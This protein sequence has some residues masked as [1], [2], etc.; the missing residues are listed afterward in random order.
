[1]DGKD[2][3]TEKSAA[4]SQVLIGCWNVSSGI[5]SHPHLVWNVG[6]LFNGLTICTTTPTFKQISV[7][8]MDVDFS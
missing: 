8:R 2:T 6:V 5:V 7:S 3:T 1:M 4:A